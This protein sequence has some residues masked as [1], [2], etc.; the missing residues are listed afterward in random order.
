MNRLGIYFFFDKDGIV[1]DYVLYFLKNF[2]KI[3]SEVCVVVNGFLT[4]ISQQKLND[5]CNKLIIR[6]N[7]GFDSW[8][9]KRAIEE[10]GYNNIKKYDEL[11]LCNFT[12]FGPIYPLEE[13]FLN[14]EKRNCDFWGI[15]RHRYEPNAYMAGVEICEHIQSHFMVFKNSILRSIMFQNYWNELKPINTYEEAVAYHELKATKYFEELGFKSSTFINPQKYFDKT[16]NSSVFCGIQ[17]V[18]EDRCPI[19]KRKVFFIKNGKIEFSQIDGK[20]P[21][22]DLKFIKNNTDYPIKY[23]EQNIE[24][25]FGKLNNPLF[26]I[27]LLFHKN[28]KGQQKTYKILGIPILTTKKKHKRHITIKKYYIL[29][30]PFYIK[31]SKARR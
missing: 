4:D 11:V 16:G 6:D 19:L 5:N 20:N 1:D 28:K 8:A 17:Q 15:H 13:M 27:S 18:K 10:Y 26:N 22:T 31:H 3:C 25:C 14:M 23:I 30:I 7:K 24:R 12:F 2:K 9:Y 29:G 21:F